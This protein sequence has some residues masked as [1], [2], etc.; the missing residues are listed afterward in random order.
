MVW[1]RTQPGGEHINQ[2]G[3]ALLTRREGT[4]P[5]PGVSRTSRGGVC[6]PTARPQPRPQTLKF[7]SLPAPHPPSKSD[8]PLP[9]HR[10]H[11][12][13]K[14]GRTLRPRPGPWSSSP[15]SSWPR[16]IRDSAQAPPLHP[17][18]PRP[19]LLAAPPQ[20]PPRPSAASGPASRPRL[21][22]PYSS[23]SSPAPPTGPTPSRP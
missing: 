22:L 8:A 2:L 1:G 9:S 16:P 17:L 21:F 14:P 18:R 4:A 23:A 5:S 13:P 7:P 20:A 3:W 15:A 12:P 19:V 10:P 6:G 11:T